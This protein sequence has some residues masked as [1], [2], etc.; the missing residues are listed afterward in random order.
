MPETICPG[1]EGKDMK[2]LGFLFLIALAYAGYNGYTA[3]TDTVF[4]LVLFFMAVA[5]GQQHNKAN[6]S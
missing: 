3:V 1:Y 4:A 5:C 6:K 2:I